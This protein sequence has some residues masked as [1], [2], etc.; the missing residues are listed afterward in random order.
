MASPFMLLLLEPRGRNIWG[1]VH[2][3]VVR[4]I[5]LR[6]SDYYFGKIRGVSF[7]KVLFIW[8]SGFGLEREIKKKQQKTTTTCDWIAWRWRFRLL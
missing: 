1:L 5:G 3:S 7:Q 8:I 6:K 4:I 2:D